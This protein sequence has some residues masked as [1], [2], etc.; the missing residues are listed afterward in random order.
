MNDEQ[1]ERLIKAVESIACSLETVEEYL[2]E[3]DE[4]ESFGGQRNMTTTLHPK[5]SR[6][7]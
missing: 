6:F 2:E 5:R 3:D 1:F 4:E 7:I